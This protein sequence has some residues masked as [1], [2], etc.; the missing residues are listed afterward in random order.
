MDSRRFVMSVAWCTAVIAGAVPAFAGPAADTTAAVTRLEAKNQALRADL[1]AMQR[2]LQRIEAERGETWLNQRRAEEV[3]ALI[4]EVLSDAEA[5]ASLLD[6][7]LHAGHDGR[8]FFLQSADGG[9]LLRIA[10]QVQFRFIANWA[11]DPFVDNDTAAVEPTPG[12]PGSPAIPGTPDGLDDQTLDEGVSG[13]TF[14]RLKLKLSG[15][16]TANP[17]IDYLILM[18]ASGDDGDWCLETAKIGHTFANGLRVQ[19]GQMQ[20]PFLR[21]ELVS[22]ARQ[23]AVERGSATEYFTLDWGQ[24]VEL[25][26]A[27]DD[28]RV[29]AAVSDGADSG[30]VNWDDDTAD[31]ALTGRADV[32]LAGEWAQAA[33]FSAWAGEPFAAFL[34]AA[35][36]WEAAETGTP[37]ANNQVTLWTV[38][39]L[40]ESGGVGLMAAVMGLHVDDEAGP[41]FDDYGVQL[42]LG[43][44]LIPDKL[45]PFLRY[46]YID[47]DGA[48]EMNLLTVGCNYYLAR[49]NAKLTADVIYAFDPLFDTPRNFNDPVP[50]GLGLRDDVDGQ[51]GQ[52]ALRIQFQMLF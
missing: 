19:A 12:D 1:E 23:L 42:E 4:A 37:A 9:F 13:F 25:S 26:Y 31:I 43:C 32:R 20:L 22:S 39:G 36:H 29:A 17:R 27:T 49:H 41:D 24:G 10:G 51:D 40:V 52:T 21:E 6:Q 14:R 34:G 11:D 38:D 33:D 15:H 3:K 8:Q 28:L 50:S 16:V 48:G 45:Q 35:V 18:A 5:R 47:V 44:F 46:D 2:R 7:G 30:N